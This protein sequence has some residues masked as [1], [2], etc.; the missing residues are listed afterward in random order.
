M[1][2]A[3]A[4]KALAKNRGLGRKPVGS[5]PSVIMQQGTALKIQLAGGAR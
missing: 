3:P 2:F 1:T 5:A 4:L